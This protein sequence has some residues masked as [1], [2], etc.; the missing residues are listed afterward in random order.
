MKKLLVI[1]ILVPLRLFADAGSPLK[2]LVDQQENFDVKHYR[3][4]LD[5]FPAEERIHGTVTI[6]AASTLALTDEILL[7]LD[8]VFNVPNVTGNV[9]GFER[10]NDRV[11]VRLDRAYNRDELFSVVVQFDGYPEQ[12]YGADE[13][14]MVFRTRGGQN[15]VFTDNAPWYA[16]NWFP[17]KDVPWDKA[18]SLDMI[19]TIP[20]GMIVASNGTLVLQQDNGDDTSTFHWSEKYPIA[21]YLISLAITN[22][23][24]IEDYYVSPAGDTLLLQH[25]V[26]PEDYEKAV[27]NFEDIPEIMDFLIGLFGDYPFEGEKCG[28]AEYEGIYA[29]MENQTM[30]HII[31][32]SVRNKDNLLYAHEISHMW[33]GDCVTM[34]N[35][36]H[37]WLNEG[38]ATYCEALWEEH[39]GGS[40]A[41][42][43]YMTRTINWS[44]S[45]KEPM[46][47]HNNQDV[48]NQI[49]YDK[50]AVVLHMLRYVMGDDQF[51]NIFP[52]YFRRYK[53]SNAL[54]E[55]LQ[56]V[57]E[58]IY[59]IPLDWFFD[60]WVMGSSYPVYSVTSAWEIKETGLKVSGY[61]SQVQEEDRIYTMPLELTFYSGDR[62]TTISVFVDR[63]G[64]PFQFIWNTVSDLSIDSVVV[65]KDDWVLNGVGTYDVYYAIDI[66]RVVFTET[67]GNGNGRIDGNETGQLTI[68]V[69]NLGDSLVN[70]YGVLESNCPYVTVLNDSVYFGNMGLYEHIDPLHNE[71]DPFTFTVDSEA[72]HKVAVFTLTL[73]GT[74]F[75]QKDSFFIDIGTADILWINGS[76][77]AEY[78]SVY[79][80][81]AHSARLNIDFLSGPEVVEN[82]DTLEQYKTVVWCTDDFRFEPLN[83]AEQVAIA[84]YLDGGGDLV[85]SGQDLAFGLYRAGTEEDSLF[86][87]KYLGISL[88]NDQVNTSTVIGEKT[89]SL[90]SDLKLALRGIYGVRNQE[91]V[92]GLLALEGGEPVLNYFPA[93]SCAGVKF[94]YSRH[95]KVVTLGFGLEGICGP[96]YSSAADLLHKILICFSDTPSR[97]PEPADKATVN[98][99]LLANYPNPFNSSTNI[100]FSVDR[101]QNVRLDIYNIMGQ[102]VNT[103]FHRYVSAGF[104]HCQWNGSDVMGRNVPAGVYFGR[105]N[106]AEHRRVVKMLYIP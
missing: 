89:D 94:G 59:R 3:I 82:P 70:F 101:P 8:R 52:E 77:K 27:V 44:K 69:Q 95:S 28:L 55:D 93:P 71:S 21:T 105:L 90:F 13:A 31:A 1:C 46:Y 96:K 25:F 19:V 30:I 78:Y 24:T 98:F 50:G 5:V 88:E 2:V 42:H 86:A 68:Y 23:R 7:D 36:P 99:A 104:F 66:P 22:F 64:A 33:W 47:R 61:V 11:A 37:T 17:C 60:Q 74:N 56:Q 45:F 26:Y 38:F 65:D 83:Q 73:H 87:K 9:K 49:V 4:E 16:R 75:F 85:I 39:T 102:H 63:Q 20:T 14:G 43:D 62:D 84:A 79:E 34:G 54:T 91:Q 35:W 48:Y 18:D 15:A 57:C 97:I 40:E 81:I 103:L 12:A 58:D 6:V 67:D 53:F 29:G 51:F 92:D 106:G 100:P 72:E 41:Y 80:S 76:D 32:V 10:R